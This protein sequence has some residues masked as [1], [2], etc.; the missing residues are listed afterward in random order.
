LSFFIFK[1]IVEALLDSRLEHYDGYE[2]KGPV[3]AG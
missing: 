2:M 3:N 1:K